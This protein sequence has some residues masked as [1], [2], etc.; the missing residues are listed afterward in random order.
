MTYAKSHCLSPA[1]Q[2]GLVLGTS[3]DAVDL[4]LTLEADRQAYRNLVRVSYQQARSVSRS[5]T[6]F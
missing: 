4:E 1:W 5:P 3:S 6:A 2:L